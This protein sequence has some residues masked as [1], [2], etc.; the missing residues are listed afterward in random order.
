MR[1]HVLTHFPFSNGDDDSIAENISP[2]CGLNVRYGVNFAK[3]EKNG[4]P[5]AHLHWVVVHVR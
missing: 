1:V 2:I 3:V 4:Y 5:D